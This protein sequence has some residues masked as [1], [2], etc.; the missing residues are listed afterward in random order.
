MGILARWKARAKKEQRERYESLM[1]Q[2][3]Q[4]LFIAFKDIKAN[5][6]SCGE[7]YSTR[8]IEWHEY[9]DADLHYFAGWADQQFTWDSDDEELLDFADECRRQ[10]ESSTR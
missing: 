9:S 1:N 4:Q 10:I 2:Q 5:T 8:T 7:C 6:C 3:A